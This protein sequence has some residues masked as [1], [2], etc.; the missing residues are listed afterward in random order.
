MLTFSELKSKCKEAI[1]DTPVDISEESVSV[2]C[3][4]EWV[5]ILTVFDPDTVGSW[6]IEVEVSLPSQMD[7]EPRNG[8]KGF[9]QNLITHLEYLLRLKDEGLTLGVIS[10]DG[11]WTAYMEI[12][13]LP[14]D[15]LFKALVPPNP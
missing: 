14:T 4:N 9:I 8:V 15:N 12:D 6:R 10:R 7:F 2:L 5:R 11:L 13:D 1:A 3:Q